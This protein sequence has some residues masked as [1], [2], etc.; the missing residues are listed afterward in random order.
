MD[1]FHVPGEPGDHTAAAHVPEAGQGHSR[2]LGESGTTLILILV[3][4]VEER[5][6]IVYKTLWR[7]QQQRHR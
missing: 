2:G 7:Q 5:L 6:S 1:I 3:S 4:R